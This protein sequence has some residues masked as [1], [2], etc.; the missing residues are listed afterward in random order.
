MAL[1]AIANYYDGILD[2]MNENL[3]GSTL[4]VILTVPCFRVPE[5]ADD[6][7]VEFSLKLSCKD[8]LGISD[9]SIGLT[10][11]EEVFL[12]VKAGRE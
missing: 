2:F 9:L 5:I 1:I 3:D 7:L 4:Q 6:E 11:L 12:T 8:E 10:T